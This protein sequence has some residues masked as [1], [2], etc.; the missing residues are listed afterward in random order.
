MKGKIQKFFASE[1]LLLASR[2]ILGSI[3]IAAS[4]GKLQHPGEFTTLV[5][6]YNI[7]PYSL[8][9]VYGYI[10]PW[11]ELLIG[12]LLI[13]GLLT[14]F[15]SAL[16]LPLIISFLIASSS[17]L[18]SG[19][20][21][22]C[23]CFGDVMPLTLTQ[24]LNL[25]ALM[26]LLAIPLMLR[27]SNLLR[28]RQWLSDSG[29]RSLRTRGFA[30]SGA[31]RVLAIIAIITLLVSSSPQTVQASI[32][33]N[34]D[35]VTS[36]PDSAN[37]IVLDEEI[38]EPAGVKNVIKAPAANTVQNVS[39]N[40]RINTALETKDAVFVLFSADWCGYCQKQKPI[41][42]MLEPEFSGDI[43][44]MRVNVDENRQAMQQFGVTGFPTMFLITGTDSNGSFVQQKFGGYT[45]EVKLKASLERIISGGGPSQEQGS[46]TI[47]P[48]AN[49]PEPMPNTLDC[50]LI[51]N[52]YDCN[53]MGCQWCETY[54]VCLQATAVCEQCSDF[55]YVKCG[56]YPRCKWCVDAQQC[57]L[58]STNCNDIDGDGILNTA[59]NCPEVAN[60][61]QADSDGDGVGDAC[62]NCLDTP[63]P[64]QADSD[65]DGVGDA[66]DQQDCGN[67]IHE[68]SEECD[69]TQYCGT[70]CKC[71]SGY[72]PDPENPGF[73]KSSAVCGN[74]ILEDGEECDG[75]RFCLADCKCAPG[76][77][78][79]PQ[80]PG[81]CKA[82]YICGN[83]ILEPGEEC[84]V[85]AKN[86]INCKCVPPAFPDPLQPGFCKLPS[87]C[88]NLIVE[89]GEE[90]DS[91][92]FCDANCLCTEGYI[93]DP[94][95]P[96]F[97][98]AAAICGNGIL[99]PGEQCES[100][101]PHCV[102][103][104]CADG[105]IPDPE[106]P[107]YC[108]VIDECPD[109]PNKTSPGICG[110]G[111]PDTDSDN[112]GTADCNDLCPNDLGKTA[113]GIC[114]CGVADTDSDGD[115]VMDCN[116]GCPDDPDKVAP[117][118]CGCGVADTD[119]DNDGVYTCQGDLCDNDPNKTDPGVCGC[120]VADTDSD[121][122]GTADC[123]DG[124]PDD[125][126]KTE[127]G[128]CG[129]GVA[130]VDTDMDGVMDCMDGCPNDPN[131]TESGVC[132]C[133]VADVDTDM[134]GVMD[135]MDGCPN[136]SG[137]TEP[138]IC[139]CGVADTDSD[140]DGVA[141]CN[142]GC[143][144]DPVKTEPGIC[145]C[146]VADVDTDMDG[147]M[148][149]MDGCPN[150]PAKTEPGICGCGVADVDTDMDGVMDCMDGCPN[151]PNKTEPGVC[152][153]GVAD[154]D[155][156]GDGVADCEDNCPD[157]ANPDQADF[158]GDGLGDACDPVYATVDIDPN[159]L[160]LKSKSDRNAV[161]A[162]IELPAEAEVNQVD[163][164]TVVLDINGSI[165]AAQ[166]R[167]TSVGDHDNDGITD[168]MVKFE[169][170]AMISVLADAK[171]SIWQNI[172]K[173]FGWKVDLKL[174]VTGYLHDGRY[175]IGEDTIKVILPKK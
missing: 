168:I 158:D 95:Y 148:D 53:R 142:D 98:K 30:L 23:G 37:T 74:G 88:G 156:D 76:Y 45:D 153:C 38:Q 136:D 117:G 101:S 170:Q 90:C 93:P 116:D 161:T 85:G 149:C 26:L 66:C 27:N 25:D 105:Y 121:G 91:T 63:N 82:L 48:P 19:A 36:Q 127:P 73:C 163:I 34:Q 18:L 128:I 173:F 119:S 96:G 5:A 146:G 58:Y 75:T 40:A 159:S 124:C 39:L 32:A 174:I 86:C 33:N 134:D 137:K 118:I 10:V 9:E 31:G 11:L 115:G 59:D 35:M 8:A 135:C 99:E 122:D 67:L 46:A 113:P 120:G 140:G 16:S 80:Y 42:D 125:P 55:D 167:P 79:D 154:T 164:N 107:G 51:G 104:Q 41:L 139:G 22:G 111:T 152:G 129:C 29:Y 97:C 64:D 103:C 21:G 60:P 69:G 1:K 143:P 112:D 144:D 20:G 78:P 92:P 62:D 157:R 89:E 12:S 47:A 50:Y 6:S 106:N 28:L 175:F 56:I 49:E 77:E 17:K 4:I 43:T 84:E 126:A 110:C 14:R 83:G 57:V 81:Y 54:G 68:G 102:N 114:G 141:D 72:M 138:G 13:L 100:F 172:G 108:T 155:S 130:D 160:N 3:F 44:F 52:E 132:G 151:D 87:V 15:A 2:L 162:Y 150:D 145:G 65:G 71:T 171:L 109:D 7:L 133:G 165:I 61:D 131:K 166:L 94:E 169:R 24:S 70:D 147:V 123:N